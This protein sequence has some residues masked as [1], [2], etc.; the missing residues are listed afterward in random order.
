[1]KRAAVMAV[2][3]GLFVL[4]IYAQRG[5]AHGGFSGSH[6][7][8]GFS[9]PHGG[10]SGGHGFAPSGGTSF[11]S[12]P[13]NFVHSGPPRFAGGSSASRSFNPQLPS[14]RPP[15][16]FPGPHPGQFLRP[17]QSVSARMPYPGSRLRPVGPT[18]PGPRQLNPGAPHRM[19]YQP[20]GGDQH[21]AGGDHRGR[22]GDHDHHHDGG[23]H[24]FGFYGVYGW[25][26]YPYWP[27]W[28]WNYPYLTNYWDD[29]DYDSQP[30]GNYSATQYPEY[31]PAQNDEPGPDESQAQQPEYTPWP[32]SRPAPSGSEPAT[33]AAT[34]AP[35]APVTLVFKD[36]RPNE[37]VRN[38]LLTS[39]TLAV[40]DQRRREIPVD[41]IDIPATAR[42]NREAGVDFA[43]PARPN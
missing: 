5:G 27:W 38:Y 21:G 33:A 17:P 14:G 39:S 28:G 34:P 43:I 30:A 7:G 11:H 42:V 36:G 23:H 16:R 29:S 9:A 25:A 12:G 40:L 2:V 35:E 18:L 31:N 24:G 41:Q 22:Y 6:G 1:M 37:Q 4:P 3:V 8:G 32:Y 13:G 15:V 20:H 10:F 26:G 19:P